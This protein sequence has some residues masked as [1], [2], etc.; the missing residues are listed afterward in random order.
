[1]QVFVIELEWNNRERA[2]IYRSYDD[3]FDMQCALLYDFPEEAGRRGAG[4]R[5]IPYLPGKKMFG[6]HSQSL[7]QERSPE[8]DAY[9]RTLIALPEK[10]S[11]N[12]RVLGF[13]R[14]TD[15]DRSPPD[16]EEEA[17]IYMDLTGMNGVSGGG[18]GLRLFG[19]RGDGEQRASSASESGL[20]L[21][22]RGYSAGGS[23]G[24]GEDGGHAHG[25][26]MMDNVMLSNGAADGS[27]VRFV[28]D[29]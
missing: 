19:R 5:T 29:D 6:K 13:L 21:R 27:G 18:G 8:I 15:A 24:G 28:E 20:P 9:M 7:A 12:A 2:T 16:S 25:A 22:Q 4:S 3:F 26:S 10:I 14:P 17:T 1:V 23:S 11:R